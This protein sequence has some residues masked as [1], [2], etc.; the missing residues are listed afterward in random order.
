MVPV[1]V[2]LLHLMFLEYI[3]NVYVVEYTIM[4]MLPFTAA[5][6]DLAHF[7]YFTYYWIV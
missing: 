7:Y 6:E 2:Q 5:D 3:I 1:S 4:C